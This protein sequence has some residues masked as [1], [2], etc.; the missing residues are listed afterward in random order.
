MRIEDSLVAAIIREAFGMYF[1][2]WQRAFTTVS[3]I[4][5]ALSMS[6]II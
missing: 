4:I 1:A 6:S 5:C 3:S 2:T